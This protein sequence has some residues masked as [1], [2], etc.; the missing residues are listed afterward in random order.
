MHSGP[1]RRSARVCGAPAPPNRPRS[2]KDADIGAIS[3][4]VPTLDR[5]FQP[6]HAVHY[7]L[8]RLQAEAYE[9]E[10]AALAELLARV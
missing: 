10:A 1:N 6:S 9:T 8:L 3:K 7:H 4:W 2:Q 5:K